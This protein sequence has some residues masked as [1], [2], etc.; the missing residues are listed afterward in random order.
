[1]KERFRVMSKKKTVGK[2]A[3]CKKK[4]IELRNS[5]IVPRLVYQRIKSH[6]NTRFRNIFSIK[7]IYQDGEKKPMLCA[8][9]EKFFNNYETTYIL[10]F[11]LFTMN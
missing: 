8:E 5:H 9:C 2:C 4:N 3:L 6:P 7:D 1:M 11:Q 10:Y